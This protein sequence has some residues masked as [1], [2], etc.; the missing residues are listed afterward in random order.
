MQVGDRVDVDGSVHV[1]L[2]ISDRAYVLRD[3][4]SQQA[5]EISRDELSRLTLGPT[6]SSPSRPI[7]DPMLLAY[8]DERTRAE[9]ELWA[10]TLRTLDVEL[11]Q[12]PAR[13]RELLAEAISKLEGAGQVVSERTLRRKQSAFKEH[14]ILSLVDGRHRNGRPPRTD[15]RILTALAE[16]MDAQSTASTGTGT[17]LINLTASALRREYGADA[18]AMPTDRTMRRLIKQLDR[19]RHT[20]GS[21]KNRQS[22]ANRP[23]RP[24]SATTV[25]TPGEQVQI[26]STVLDVMVS[27]GDGVAGRPELTIMLDVATRSILAAVLRAGGTK[28]TDLVVCLA[29]ALVPY[30]RRPSGR[31]ETRSLAT[32]AFET[33]CL[34]PEASY[35]DFRAR[36]PYIFPSSITTDRGKIFVSEHFKSVCE[37][38]GISLV[39]SA[40]HTP[41]DKGKVERTFKTINT[42]FTQYLKSYTGRSVEHR[43]LEVPVEKLNT[44]VEVQELLDEWIAVHWQNRPHGGLRDPLRPTVTLSPNEM[45]ETMNSLAPQLQ[46]PFTEDTYIE[47]LP[48]Q[49]R[50]I[51][52]YGV[53]ID[54]RTYDSAALTALRRTS[55]PHKHKKG[56]W[57]I[58]VDPYNIQTVWIQL[59]GAWHPLQ[60]AH[61][62][63]TGPLSTDVWD[64]VRKS[65]LFDRRRATEVEIADRTRALLEHAAQGTGRE[66]KA[67][68]RSHAVNHAQPQ[69]P[70]SPSARVPEQEAERGPSNDSEVIEMPRP[71]LRFDLFNPEDELE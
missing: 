4:A 50:T 40:P 46:I 24:F 64:S 17:R 49:W 23:D 56:A 59:E 35:A 29:R 43:G 28:S 6:T 1:V 39:L 38:L 45:F 16:V 10:D 41:T 11:A 5:L 8:L 68:A 69:E 15:P 19:G 42:L 32:L 66:Q 21:A 20:T 61:A 27:L 57:P 62:E 2:A 7:D 58:H 18:V 13:R 70:T 31:L 52:A 63:Y 48:I 51:Q 55:S 30:D 22:I 60:W 33:G 71:R 47:L 37:T 12:N 36:M 53:S 65:N 25:S 26:D 44:L 14:G 34:L 9:V 67:I 3:E 54:R